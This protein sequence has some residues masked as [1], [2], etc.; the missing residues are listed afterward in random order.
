MDIKRV[1]IFKGRVIKVID[2]DTIRV[3]V[4]TRFN[5]S[6]TVD[7]RLLGINAKERHTEEGRVVKSYLKKLIEGK[8]VTIKTLKLKTK[9]KQAKT[10]S[11]YIAD[12]WL[13]G[14]NINTHLVEKGYAVIYK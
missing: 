12:I 6:V 7:L 13:D 10:F 5:Q 1:D 4:D 8:E 14:L 3:L 9:D 2:G 11:R